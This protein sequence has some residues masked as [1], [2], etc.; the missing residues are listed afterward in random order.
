MRSKRTAAIMAAIAIAAASLF[1]DGLTARFCKV[2]G[3][4]AP[5]PPVSGMNGALVR[6]AFQRIACIMESV[7][8]RGGKMKIHRTY[9]FRL[10]PDKAQTELLARR[11]GCCRP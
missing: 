5:R 6:F 4:R 1:A 3:G 8:K 7:G 11:F 10:Y 9:R 2:S